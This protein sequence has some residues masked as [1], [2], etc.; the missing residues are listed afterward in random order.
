MAMVLAGL[1]LVATP[2]VA[3][4]RHVIADDRTDFSSVKTFLLRAGRATTTRPELNNALVLKKVQ[5]AIRAQLVAKGL[6]ETADD[7]DVTLDFT[8]GEDR[9][10]GPSVTFDRGVLVVR[11]TRR[12]SN[13][14]I[15]QG[16]YTDDKSD[17]AALAGKIPGHVRK[18][19][20]EY[21]PKK[22]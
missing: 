10:N 1:L 5:D 3:D 17:P 13:D 9:P 22:K 12:E 11:M 4:Y 6:K 18:L 8:V 20:S 14:L 21:P 19:L 16:V 7:A 2:L 15:W